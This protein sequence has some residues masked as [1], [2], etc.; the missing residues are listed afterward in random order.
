MPLISQ[1]PL[2]NGVRYHIGRPVVVER[3]WWYP[4][5]AFK[6]GQEV[7]ISADGCVQIGGRGKT[8]KR[9]VDPRGPSSEKLYHALVAIPG[10]TDGLVRLQD[11]VDIPL[12]IPTSSSLILGFEDDFYPD[13]GYSDPSD[14]GTD[15]QCTGKGDASVTVTVTQAGSSPVP[16]PPQVVSAGPHERAK[17]QSPLPAPS[18][19]INAPSCPTTTPAPPR[20]RL[21]KR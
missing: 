16:S 7:T 8:R 17:F 19:G 5:I 11:V 14:P 6:R 3:C 10:V 4:A 15:C 1:E 2:T 21:R 12:A 20:S 13:N 18:P 9:Y